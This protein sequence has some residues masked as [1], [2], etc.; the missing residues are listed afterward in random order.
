MAEW[1]VVIL[2]PAR[3]YLEKLSRKEQERIL[4]ALE[5]LPEN[6][7]LLFSSHVTDAPRVS[8]TNLSGTSVLPPTTTGATSR[9]IEVSAVLPSQNHTR[10]RPAVLPTVTATPIASIS[11]VLYDLT[12]A[13]V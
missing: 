5:K 9:V 1:Q 3:R 13:I 7:L 10:R 2:R 4:N 6:L 12:A 8:T 11:V